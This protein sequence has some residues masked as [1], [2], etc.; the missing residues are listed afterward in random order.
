MAPGSVALAVSEGVPIFEAAIPCEVFGRPRRDL[1]DPWYDFRVCAVDPGRTRLGGG[2]IAGTAHG[3]EDL[4]GADTVIVPACENV[5]EEQPAELVEAVR[6]AHSRGARIVSICSGAFVLA[7]AGL[8]DGRTATLHWMHADLLARRYPRVRVD[9]TV[10]YVDGGD[11]LTSAGTAAGLDLC[12]HL[13]RLDL[14][15]EIANLLARRLIIHAHRPGGQAQFVEGPVPR[16]EDEALAPLL[17]WALEHLDRPLTLDDMAARCH[18]T[19]RT[20]I[21]RFHAATGT[22]PLRW[23]LSQRVQRARLL[24]ESTDDPVG[25]VAERCGLGTEANL[26]HH[27]T[28]GVGVAPTEYRRTFRGGVA[29]S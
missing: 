23:L 21:R 22:A 29:A 4:A 25:L 9:P 28:R 1:A 13:V 20:L 26:R 27:F 16:H 3:L 10:L 8:L 11:V 6:A 17:H 12:L 14:G 18:V 15:A 24:L 5:H 2:F 19:T 7:A